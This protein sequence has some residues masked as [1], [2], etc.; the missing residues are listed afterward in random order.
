MR[1]EVVDMVN[2]TDDLENTEVGY[3]RCRGEGE[4]MEVAVV[5]EREAAEARQG[6]PSKGFRR[7]WWRVDAKIGEDEICE[8][9]ERERRSEEDVR[10]A[11]IVVQVEDKVRQIA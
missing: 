10:V 2:A 8:V 3:V 4:V 6:W 11:R 7:V 1:P 5:Q 9:R